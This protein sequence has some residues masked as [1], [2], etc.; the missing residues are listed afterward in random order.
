LK[1]A[2]RGKE[3]LDR[4]VSVYSKYFD[5]SFVVVTPLTLLEH[6]HEY[7]RFLQEE[8][9]SK[10]IGLILANRSEIVGTIIPSRTTTVALS[11][12]R[13]LAKKMRLRSLKESKAHHS[14]L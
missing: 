8:L 5:D 4:Q 10:G 14:L 11:N 12:R 9:K 2:K 3:P 6:G 13:L 7:F 1:T